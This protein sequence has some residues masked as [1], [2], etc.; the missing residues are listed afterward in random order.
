MTSLR[1]YLLLFNWIV[2]SDVIYYPHNNLIHWIY[3][4]FMVGVKFYSTRLHC[5]FI[6]VG[7][8]FLP[9]LM[10]IIIALLLEVSHIMLKGKSL[11]V[12]QTVPWQQ[13]QSSCAANRSCWCPSCYDNPTRPEIRWRYTGTRVRG[14]SREAISRR[15][16]GC[17]GRYGTGE[18]LEWERYS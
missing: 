14:R 6:T 12:V 10:H 13:S 9:S 18:S 3:C 1:N 15:C 16:G 4:W 17:S 7:Q 11:P 8:K 2:D 5:Q